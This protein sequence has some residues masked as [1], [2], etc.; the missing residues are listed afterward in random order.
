[1]DAR[2]RAN[3]QTCVERHNALLACAEILIRDGFLRAPGATK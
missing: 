3:W 2:N 1:M